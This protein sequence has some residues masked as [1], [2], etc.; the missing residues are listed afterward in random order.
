M[1]R[2]RVIF[3]KE[4]KDLSRDYR[5]LAYVVL[6]PLIALP[7]MAVLAGGLYT[8]QQ[9]TVGVVDL[10]GTEIS[11]AFVEGLVERLS[12]GVQGVALEVVV[13]GRGDFT[14][15]VPEGF[16]EMVESLDGRTYVELSYVPGPP[17]FSSIESIVRSY[18][19]QFER[20]VVEARVS[21]LAEAAGLEVDEGGLLDPIQVRVT[22]LTP[23]G[24]PA[25]GE[26]GVVAF[27]AR[28]IAF[29]LFFVV[30]PAVVFM[31]DAVV[32][33]RERRS[34]ERLLSAPATPLEVLAGK[35]AASMLLSLAAAVADSVAIVAFFV[36]SGT[37]VE[38]GAYLA[39]AWALSTL[40]LV[41]FT[42]ALVA[43]LSAWSGSLR[44]AQSTSFAVLMAAL[45]V[46]FSSLVVDFDSLPAWA[47]AVLLAV[48]FTHAS[49]AV[50][51]ASYG[52]LA[53]MALHL[54]VLLAFT[55]IAVV[56]ARRMFTPERLVAFKG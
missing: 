19:A 38:V 21:A 8:A 48:P 23:A 5:T 9:V 6:L 54:A 26:A 17:V 2:A 31:S 16:G 45:A 27:S 51:R 41:A 37:S 47:R 49:L 14:I 32:G 34:I 43:A 20:S 36:L 30:N 40:A 46:Y 12:A 24:E 10:D 44:S 3:W 15:I 1:R 52:D 29:S 56:A 22:F 4:V 33:E 55:L 35:M 7:G 28:V 53:G 39:A 11:R 50:F 13:G 25:G 42:S 18:V